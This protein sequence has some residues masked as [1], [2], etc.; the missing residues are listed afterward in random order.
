MNVIERIPQ[1]EGQRNIR[2]QATVLDT[3]LALGGVLVITGIMVAFHLY[4]LIPN[5][6]IIYLLL[7][8][9]LAAFRSRYPAILASIA[10][11]LAFNFFLVPPL[12]T[13]EMPPGGWV[14]LCIFLLTA[15]IT[16]QLAAVS[17]LRERETRRRERETCI[18]YEMMHA[19]NSRLTFDEQLDV[20]ALSTVRV[21]SPWGVSE[22]A[23]LLPDRNKHLVVRA[24][25]PIQ[26]E[27]FTLSP[28]QLSIAEQVMVEGKSRE[29]PHT[30]AS[31]GKPVR[32][33]LIPL[34]VHEQ[35]LGVLALHVQDGD[36]QFMR[37]AQDNW[38]ESNHASAF[39]WTFLDQIIS[40]IDREDLR[41][42]MA[43]S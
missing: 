3:L 14:A 28:E 16:S 15:L 5:I 40:T 9:P 34:Q 2:W 27:S 22:C 32:L 19:V 23:L 13:F 6:S 18:L 29:V 20:M 1:L 24:D 26:I 35:R 30:L 38:D 10:A 39:F 12:Y 33:Y 41:L 42:A 36:V 11:F 37:T 43:G 25:G 4:P 7:I 17:R 31:S 21:F 8:L